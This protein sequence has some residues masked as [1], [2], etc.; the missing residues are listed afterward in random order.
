MSELGS[1]GAQ[2]H[3]VSCFWRNL[4]DQEAAPLRRQNNH[5]S[6]STMETH[7]GTS[8]AFVESFQA[9]WMH[10]AEM[11]ILISKRPHGPH[12]TIYH[13]ALWII[14]DCHGYWL[15]TLISSDALHLCFEIFLSILTAQY[16]SFHLRHSIYRVARNAKAFHDSFELL[17]QRR[18]NA[19][20]T[21]SAASAVRTR[22]LNKSP[23]R[24]T[25]SCR[26]HCM[27][28]STCMEYFNCQLDH[29][30]SA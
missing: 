1:A 15:C 9:G 26:H 23:N 24:T 20:I 7:V 28:P 2:H 16:Q 13:A 21:H 22:T 14:D 10:E 17:G 25:L 5:G 6:G 4:V 3:F 8:S 19:C 29:L 27:P 12:R 30:L 18:E 11:G